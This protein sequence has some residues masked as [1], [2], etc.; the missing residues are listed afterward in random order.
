MLGPTNTGKTHLAVE[1]LCGHASGII[2]FPLRLLA[3]EVYEKVVALKGEANVALITGEEKI[4]PPNAK[5]FLSTVEAMPLG[6]AGDQAM[7]AKDVAFVAIDEG[8]VAAD[9]ERGH[10]FTDRLLHARGYAETMILGSETLRPLVRKLLPDA[11]IIT[12]PRFSTLTYAGS[13]KL[14]RLPRRC[15]IVAFT[16]TE[17]YALAEMLR[18]Q[19]G[20]AAVVM[21]SLSPRTRNAQVAMYQSGE[22]DYIVA[23]DA[24]GMGLNM[25]IAHVAFASLGK[26]DGRRQRR[27]TLSEMA[28][29]AGRAGRYQKDGSFGTV[30]LGTAE[31]ASFTPDEIKGLEEHRF[32]ALEH[33]VWRNTELDFTSLSRLIGSL[34]ARPPRCELVRGDDAI[35]LAVLKRL[36]GEPWVMERAPGPRGVS[37]LWAACSLPDYRKTGAEQHARLVGRVFRHLSEANGKL[38]DAWIASELAHLDRLSGDVETLADRIAGARTWTYVAHRPDWLAD[39]MHWAE[40]TRA[41]EDRL[42]DAL[43]TA[44][45]QRFVDRRT[46]VLLRDLKARGQDQ[47]VEIDPDGAVAVEGEVIGTLNGFRFTADPLA[48]AGEQRLL[49][50]AA[51]RYLFKEMARRAGQL[52]AATD[53][54]F[55]LDFAGKMPPRLLWNGARVAI[56]RKGRDAMTPRIELDRALASLSPDDRRHIQARLEGWFAGA[57]ERELGSLVVLGGLHETVSPV[58]RGLIV[59]L[60]ETLGALKRCDATDQVEAL[61]RA[62][63]QALTRAGVRMGVVHIFVATLLRPEPTRWR[64]ALWAV[65][66]EIAALPPLPVPGRVSV[67][68]DDGL[69]A[70]F[71]EAAGFWRIGSEAVRIDM[72]DRLA[73]AIHGRREGRAPFIPDPNWAASAGLTRDGLARLMRALGYRLQLV[74]GAAHFAWR[75]HRRPTVQQ[76]SVS[77]ARTLA[78]SPFAILADV[79]FGKSAPARSPAQ[80]PDTITHVGGWAGERA[81]A[82]FAAAQRQKKGR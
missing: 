30:Q 66:N 70:G 73:R 3:R 58:A 59:R 52:V 1:R 61:A 65:W 4:V 55:A 39:P 11:E 42:S 48:R 9:P 18:R 47:R 71:L 67:A 54:D 77:E 34:D 25:D 81:G 2:G 33:L 19:K 10:V 60:V 29:I 44:L 7:N 17:V 75:G 41:V 63:R 62:D 20:G 56:L 26:F 32:E 78:E 69:P 46:A 76:D 21:G 23:T 37:R 38:P 51:E 79:S 15:A 68:A 49:L 6:R 13:K 12:R 45:T 14:S 22:V 8:Q 80:P 43:H 5:Y 16:A 31:A 72:V 82:D 64:L 27:L 53:V 57:L 28:Q 24:I 35:D 36:A 50:A 74:D 40:R